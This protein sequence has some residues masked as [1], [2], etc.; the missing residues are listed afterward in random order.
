[1]KVL[2]GCD[3][4]PVLPGVLANPS[5]GTDIWACLRLLDRMVESFGAKLPPITWLI[6][7]DES[8]RFCTG[9]LDSGFLAR[10]SFWRSVIDRGHEVGWH[11]HLISFKRAAGC[12][13]FDPKPA[14]LRAAFEALASHLPVVSTRTG[15]D[16]CSNYLM[17]QFEDFGIRVDFSA[18][19]GNI[20]WHQAGPDILRVDWLRC[21]YA[22]YHPST[23]DYQSAGQMSLLEVPIAQFRNPLPA[24]VRRAAWRLGHGCMSFAGLRSRTRML[25]ELWDGLP[26]SPSPVWAFYFHPEDLSDGGLDRLIQN[27][28]RLRALPDV[29]F[30]TTSALARSMTPKDRV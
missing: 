29:Q 23:V 8:V 16:Y 2:L 15:W 12:F 3:V 13:G 11:M 9:T 30:V 18:L 28:E 19:P 10:E 22:P 17:E 14:W 5:S 1:M 27:V 21:P 7:C 20:I 25:T 4:D 26:R 6:R 24:I